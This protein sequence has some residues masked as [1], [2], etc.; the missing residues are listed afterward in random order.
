MGDRGWKRPFSRSHIVC[1]A[2]ANSSRSRTLYI[3]KLSKADQEAAE[4]QARMEALIL[5]ATLG[6]RRWSRGSEYCWRWT[7]G[8][9]IR[10]PPRAGNGFDRYRLAWLCDH[11]LCSRQY[12]PDR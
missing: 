2:A 5:G 12:M 1:R 11:G 3:T 6:G 4:W 10:Q 7:T 9:Q 8:S